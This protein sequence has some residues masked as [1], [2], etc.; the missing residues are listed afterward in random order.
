MN[1]ILQCLCN[2]P[3]LVNYFKYNKTIIPTIRS[4]ITYGNNLLSSSFK[5]LME[6]LWPDQLMAIYN[7]NPNFPI[8]NFGN[9]NLYS[10]EKKSSYAPKEFKNKICKMNPFYE[11][12]IL[13][14]LKELVRFLI[15]T[16]H[17]ELNRASKVTIDKSL[18]NQDYRNQ[19]LMF[20][21]FTSD[22]VNNNKSIISDLFYGVNY[23]IVQCQ[24]CFSKTYTYQTNFFLEFPL[25][26]VR[27]FKNQKNINNNL[28]NNMN[29]DN[30]EI[31]IYD[32]FL[33]EQR[34]I[35][36]IGENSIYCNFCKNMTNAQMCTIFTIGP[37]ILI[38]I[39][40]R[41]KGFQIKINFV[42]ELNLFNFI[43][44]KETGF[45]YKLIGVIANLGGIGINE[46]FI[47]FC[48]NPISNYW[49]QFNDSIVKEVSN[50]KNE[51]ID[52]AMPNML[53]YQK[54]NN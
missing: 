19:Q 53:I 31:N 20:D 37:E 36:M 41:G 35:Y 33:Y 30:N 9:N 45:N 13:N 42:E 51:V 1:A 34:I 15:L 6:K 18:M 11:N 14:D 49:Y 17:E 46:H 2:I 25:E 50:F 3:K 10:N 54:F 27:I 7:K 12:G 16:L 48:K 47:A 39:L 4:D 22:F 38:I 24:N 40:N 44:H 52:C 43:E 8:G 28:N 21:L 26:E 32:C 29:F 23:N 5:L